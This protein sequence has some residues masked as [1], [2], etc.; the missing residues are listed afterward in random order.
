MFAGCLTVSNS[1]DRCSIGARCQ[2]IWFAAGEAILASLRFVSLC[3]DARVV[4]WR[5][6]VAVVRPLG[7]LHMSTH[8]AL[9]KHPIRHT[10]SGYNTTDKER[11]E[12]LEARAF[13]K[14]A[15]PHHSTEWVRHIGG[16]SLDHI[17][18]LLL[19]MLN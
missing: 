3:G 15:L 7:G 14:D 5:G 4:R 10:S 16:S 8:T 17:A 9:G 11:L 2:T 12:P 18:I 13:M 19:Y 1:P 6:G